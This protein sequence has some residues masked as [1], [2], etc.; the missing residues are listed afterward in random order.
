MKITAERMQKILRRK[1]NRTDVSEIEIKWAD[2]KFAGLTAM[3]EDGKM[4]FTLNLRTRRIGMI[5]IAS[6]K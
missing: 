3:T 5:G 1:L 6:G 2:G 4:S